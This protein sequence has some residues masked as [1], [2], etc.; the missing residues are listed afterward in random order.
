MLKFNLLILPE[1]QMNFKL[2]NIPGNSVYIEIDK[3][4]DDILAQIVL[5]LISD[6]AKYSLQFDETTNASNL[7]QLAVFV[8]YG[9]KEDV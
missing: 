8:H 3:M 1:E 6:T 7:S 4:N 5:N 2:N 9:N